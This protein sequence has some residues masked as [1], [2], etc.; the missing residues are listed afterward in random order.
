M[1]GRSTTRIHRNAGH[2]VSLTGPPAALRETKGGFA[3]VDFLDLEGDGV[4]EILETS[5]EFGVVSLVKLLVSQRAETH[6][7]ILALDPKTPGGL[8]TVFEDRVALALDFHGGRFAD[9]LPG[10]GDWNGDG[11]L[12]LFV[13]RGDD[14]I[15]FRMGSR[16]PDA[17]R[18]GPLQGDQP[19][20]LASGA[21]RITD[22]N[23]DGLDEIVAFS[24]TDP[25]PPLVVLENLGRLPGS[26]SSLRPR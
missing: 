25:E 10:F 21:S 13:S 9:V 14:A 6:V 16:A 11:L 24:T 4:E 12:D 3:S 15:A 20:P 19:L 1:D 2:G 5:F 26:R 7:R 18:L 8:R 17:P 22:L 23:G